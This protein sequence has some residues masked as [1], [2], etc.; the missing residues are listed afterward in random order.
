M[1]DRR[2]TDPLLTDLNT[3]VLNLSVSVGRLDANIT[4]LHDRV[5]LLAT[6][7]VKMD[8][9][10]NN[11]SLHNCE[12]RL[13]QLQE[14]SSKVSKFEEIHQNIS[15]VRKGVTMSYKVIAWVVAGAVGF[16]GFVI[17]Y[18]DNIKSL[19]GAV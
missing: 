8:A 7:L 1:S 16:I 9:H 19:L 12:E 15:G 5:D 13:K 18:I 3:N 2:S 11:K 14:L 17:K 6:G 4:N 10:I